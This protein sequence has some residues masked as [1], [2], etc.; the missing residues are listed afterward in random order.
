MTAVA[1]LARAE[2]LPIT[3]LLVQHRSRTSHMK[4][5]PGEMRGIGSDAGLGILVP[6]LDEIHSL[7]TPTENIGCGL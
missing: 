3:R 6:I 2:G 5:K 7:H 1:A 4:K